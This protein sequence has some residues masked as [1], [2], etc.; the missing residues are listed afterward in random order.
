ML[1]GSGKNRYRNSCQ[2]SL[3]LCIP[4]SSFF[5]LDDGLVDDFDSDFASGLDS[6]LAPGLESDFD[7][8]FGPDEFELDDEEAF[9]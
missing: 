6:G 2:I 5:E 7:S 3:L 8:G 9:L 1:A 4:Y